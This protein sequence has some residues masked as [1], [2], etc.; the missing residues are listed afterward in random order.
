MALRIAIQG[1]IRATLDPGAYAIE[2]TLGR[3]RVLYTRPP[4]PA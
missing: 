2:G 4:L 3:Q 1:N